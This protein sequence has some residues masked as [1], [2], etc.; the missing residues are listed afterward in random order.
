MARAGSSMV[1]QMQARRSALMGPPAAFGSPM[2]SPPPMAPA[3]AARPRRTASAFPGAA[4]AFAGKGAKRAKKPTARTM[5]TDPVSGK[6]MAP[7]GGGRFARMER[8][9]KGK[10]RDPGAV[11]AAAGRAKYGKARFQAMAAAGRA[12]AKG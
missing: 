2:G 1:A 9:L 10:V 5:K 4:P 3:P 8:A 7:G 6:S 12:R 11:A